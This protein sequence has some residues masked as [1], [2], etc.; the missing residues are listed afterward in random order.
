MAKKFS[1]LGCVALLIAS[2]VQV[3]PLMASNGLYQPLMASHG[4]G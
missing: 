4:L 2:A 3:R 1:L